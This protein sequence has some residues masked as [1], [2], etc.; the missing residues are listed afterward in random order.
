[1][2]FLIENTVISEIEFDNRI[3]VGFKELVVIVMYISY[4]HTWEFYPLL[5]LQKSST[6]ILSKL[7]TRFSISI[8]CASFE[9]W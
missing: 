1:M 9:N 8:N 3:W 5:W 7:F 2:A 6:L 4:F